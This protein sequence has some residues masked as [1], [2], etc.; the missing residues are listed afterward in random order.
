MFSFQ[1]FLDFVKFALLPCILVRFALHE[2]LQRT[3]DALSGLLVSLWCDLAP[4]D[5]MVDFGPAES[6]IIF[7][8]LE[9][10]L[11]TLRARFKQHFRRV[12]AG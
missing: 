8:D 12:V 4:R 2:A 7:A 10:A 1:V 3:F 5:I 11:H 6:N 9:V